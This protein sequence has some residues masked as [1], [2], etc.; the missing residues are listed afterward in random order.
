MHQQGVESKSC[1]APQE[2]SSNAIAMFESRMALT[3]KGRLTPNGFGGNVWS[4]IVH[5]CCKTVDNP[6][7]QPLAYTELRVVLVELKYAL[8]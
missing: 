2:G 8:T 7:E 4:G 5:A 3:N 6:A 1:A